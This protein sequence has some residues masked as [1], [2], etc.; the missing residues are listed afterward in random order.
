MPG[1]L[2]DLNIQ[3]NFLSSWTPRDAVREL[4]A[5]AID[6]AMLTG[7]PMPEITKARDGAW[8]IR[9]WGRGLRP[10]HLTQAENVE[11]ATTDVAVIGRFGVGLKDALATLRD[12]SVGV[13]ILSPHARYTLVTHGKSGFQ[14][15]ATLHVDVDVD[16]AWAEKGTLVRLTDVGDDAVR[17]AK[18]LF[19]HF[20]PVEVLDT[21]RYGQI[22]ARDPRHPA[23]I[24]IRGLRIADEED[25]LFS[26]NITVLTKKMRDALNRERTNV[27]RTGYSDRIKSLLKDSMKPE[28]AERLA[29]DLQSLSRGDAHAE[30]TNWTDVAIH[31]CKVL[32]QR[33]KIVF[34]DAI[35]LA[36]ERHTLDEVRRDGGRVV[37]IPTR[38]L[39][40]LRKEMFDYQ[41]CPIRTLG[42]VADEIRASYRFDFVD[43]SDLDDQERTV[44]ELR[45]VIEQL[46]GGRPEAV[47]EV[48]ISNTMRPELG[49]P[50]EVL[51]LWEPEG[52]RIIVK[53]SQL[54]D[55]PAFAGTL[56][57]ELAHAQTGK[58]DV[59]RDLEER[60]TQMLGA[61]LSKLLESRVPLPTQGPSAHAPKQ[62]EA[63]ATPAQPEALPT[64]HVPPPSE[65]KPR[66]GLRERLRR[67][68]GKR[69][70]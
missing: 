16:S 6:E 30:V 57:H 44:W 63:A 64:E 42:V 34:V 32:N 69:F 3:E 22:L 19:L 53:R 24:Y 39:S 33:G 56:A 20:Q 27:G 28:V 48:L 54:R 9:D 21:G 11:K 25:F 26:Y 66:R 38:T 70:S 51:G 23:G 10:E 2:F 5:N 13:E 7:S 40:G 35:E 55:P 46:V 4:L 67:W 17:D 47:R 65:S 8:E 45:G 50:N 59:S 68:R 58:P 43:E 12:A 31:A 14:G 60:L 52:G 1:K 18:A 61:V 37:S 36:R 29:T 41:G 62:T 15:V 49:N